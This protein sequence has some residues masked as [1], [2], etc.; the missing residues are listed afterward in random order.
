MG[1][2]N[3]PPRLWVEDCGPGIPG[4]E[5]ERVVSRFYRIP[6]TPGEGCG[7]GLAIVDEIARVHGARLRILPGDGGTGTRVVLEFDED[8]YRTTRAVR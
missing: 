3:H 8:A 6:G 5:R 4:G 1:V 2:G 7:L